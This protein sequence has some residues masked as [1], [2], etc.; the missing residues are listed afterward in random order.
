MANTESRLLEGL[1]QQQG[2]AGYL[3]VGC[4]SDESVEV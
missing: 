2:H 4:K 3:L 1:E